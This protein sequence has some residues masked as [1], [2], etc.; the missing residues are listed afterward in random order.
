MTEDLTELLAEFTVASHD[1][2]QE[3]I[4]QKYP[5]FF[6]KVGR[7]EYPKRD[8]DNIRRVFG[9]YWSASSALGTAILEG[10]ECRTLYKKI[11]WRKNM[12]L[13]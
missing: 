5:W 6:I 8:H 4:F 2:Q 9:A 3:V 10:A 7:W 13:N 1:M 12:R 11:L